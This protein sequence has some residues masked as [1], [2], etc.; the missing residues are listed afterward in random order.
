MYD[1]LNELLY[2]LKESFLVRRV[3][4]TKHFPITLET[5]AF[6]MKVSMKPYTSYDDTCACTMIKKCVTMN[7]INIILNVL[8]DDNED[9]E[10][11]IIILLTSSFF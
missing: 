1:E 4:R 6:G 10:K 11:N 9:D 5:C 8:C 7:N 3:S 2:L